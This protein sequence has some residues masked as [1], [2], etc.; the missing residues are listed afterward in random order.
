MKKHLFLLPG[1]KTARELFEQLEN[2][3]INHNRIHIAHQ[4]H[5]CSTNCH[6]NHLNLKEKNDTIHS[7]DL[8]FK[9]GVVLATTVGFFTYNLWVGHPAG[10]IGTV[11]ACLIAPGFPAWLGG[12]IDP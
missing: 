6:L 12:M 2:A 7:G 3:G 5:S 10:G 11:L 8:K 1:L 4:D 9:V